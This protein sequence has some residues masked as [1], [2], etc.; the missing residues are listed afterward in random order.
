MHKPL[1]LKNELEKI[2][3]KQEFSGFF[4]V[5]NDKKKRG[6]LFIQN[7]KL[8][9][10]CISNDFYKK[11]ASEILEWNTKDVFYKEWSTDFEVSFKYIY[12]V[13][14]YVELFCLSVSLDFVFKNKQVRIFCSEG[15]ISKIE[16]QPNNV[17]TFFYNVLNENKGKFKIKKIKPHINNQIFSFTEIINTIIKTKKKVT[18]KH[19]YQ[20]I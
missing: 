3:D 8:T 13:L 15:S 19:Q 18:I 11:K 16:P 12:E 5:I 9:N 17:Y 6:V 4:S 20:T 2:T 10:A 7:G 14:C 1:N